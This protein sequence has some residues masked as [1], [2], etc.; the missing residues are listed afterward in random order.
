[1]KR[2]SGLIIALFLAVM[3][4]S[5]SFLPLTGA[6]GAGQC[7]EA[8]T[9]LARTSGLDATHISAYRALICQLVA[10]SFW[11]RFDTL[12][13][14]STADATTAGLN[15]VS[16]SYT[17]TPVSSPTFTADRGYAGNGSSSYINTGWA[18]SAGV[19]FTQNDAS[20][21][22]WSL[23]ARSAGVIFDIGQEDSGTSTTRINLRNPSN[24]AITSVNQTS[25]FSVSNTD[26]TGFYVTQ[27]TGSTAT[28]LFRNGTS[29]TTG[30]GTSAARGPYAIF[31]GAQ[32]S[33]GAPLSYSTVQFSIVFTGASFSSGEQSTLYSIF[34]QWQCTVGAISC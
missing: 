22:A 25:A 1:M 29:L 18:P 7:A 21:G 13:V 4:A 15:L 20:L 12:Y 31:F 24:L 19:N 28:E 9:F 10:N 16:T 26:T 33:G 3:P 27:R 17:L 30:T 23:T 2:I 32:N 5:A 11:S 14:L 6:G 34:R 8:S